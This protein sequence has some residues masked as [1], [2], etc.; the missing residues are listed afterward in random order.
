M[1][2]YTNVCRYGNA[3]LY[4]GYNQV[5]KRI[6]KRDTD[7]KPV[8]FT[9]TKS[10][11]DWRSIDGQP[12]APIQMDSMREA[13]DWLNSNRDVAGRKIYGNQKYLQ[14]YIT[15]RFPRDIEW[16]RECID[17]GTFDIETEYDDAE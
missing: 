8:F 13:K 5:G 12:I 17:V 16:K 2:F 10:E 14:Q 9:N 15:N 11:T 1:S 4:R 6:Y 7:F 3:V